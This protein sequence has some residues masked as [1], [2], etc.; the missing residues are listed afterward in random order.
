MHVNRHPLTWE[1]KEYDC[2]E[3]TSHKPDTAG[4]PQITVDSKN[5]R[6]HRF[7]CRELFGECPI[8]QEVLHS[9]DNRLC[10][11]PEHLRYGTR[12]ENIADMDSRGRR[13]TPKGE[14][15]GLA[16]L[17]EE[18]VRKIRKDK[19]TSREIAKSY[20]VNKGTILAIKHRRTWRHVEDEE[21]AT[22]EDYKNSVYHFG[23]EKHLAQLEKIHMQNRK[24]TKE[25]IENINSLY[26]TNLKTKSELSRMYNVSP[27][28]IHNI[29]KGKTY[30][31]F[32]L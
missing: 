21:N 23:C 5:M 20:N 6:V 28:T 13:N 27:N 30:K 8:G 4:Y 18:D 25:D 10:I 26:N 15:A 9:C 3:C 19:R 32:N 24:F 22:Y 17:T 16:K 2:W 7:L 12:K 11:N 31:E 29:V 1:V 14:N